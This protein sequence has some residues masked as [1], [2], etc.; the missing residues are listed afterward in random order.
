MKRLAKQPKPVAAELCPPE[1]VTLTVTAMPLMFA[2]ALDG[3]T[4]IQH[5]RSVRSSLG[6]HFGLIAATMRG[7]EMLT[8]SRVGR[9]ID[10]HLAAGTLS[11]SDPGD[12][13]SSSGPIRPETPKLP[14]RIFTDSQELIVVGETSLPAAPESTV[15]DFAQFR[16]QLLR[17]DVCWELVSSRAER[18][19]NLQAWAL[20]TCLV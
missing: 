1:P 15:S 16:R 10:D 8:N 17:F 4:E 2:Y 6:P 14:L 5:H 20:Q 13:Q 18:L 7:L 11:M 12:A 3:P 19:V 9:F